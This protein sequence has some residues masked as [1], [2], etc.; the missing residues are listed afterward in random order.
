MAIV[1]TLSRALAVP[2]LLALGACSDEPAPTRTAPATAAPVSPAV[3]ASAPPAVTGDP[4]ARAAEVVA[5]LSDEDL[6]GQVLMPYAY[7]SSATQVDPVNR[8]GNQQLAGVDTPAEMITKYRLG[9]L[10]LVGFAPDDPTGKTNPTTNVENPEQVRALTAGL[11][12]AAG[13]I[14]AGAPLMIGMDQE[15]GIVTRVTEGVTMLPSALAFGAARQ[16]TLTEQAWRAAGTELAAMGVTVDFAPV[17]DTLGTAGGGVIGSRSFGSDA[18]ANSQQVA[19]AVR[20]LQ[21]SGVAAALKHFPGHGHTTAD[22]HDELPLIGQS[23]KAWEQQDLPPFKAGVDAGAGVVMS[24]HLNLQAIDKGVAATFSRKI[25]TDELR[26][27][28][29]FTGVA[30]TDAMNMAP[31]QKWPAGEAAVRALNAGNDMLLMPP[32]IGAARDGIVNAL[33]NGSL[34]RER[35]TEAVTRI[36]TLKFRTAQ[37]PQPELSVIG[38]P[39]HL[40]AVSALDAAA[41]TVLRGAC[42]GPLAR[43]PVSVSAPASR[44]VA[45]VNLVKALQGAGMQVQASGGSVIRLVGYGDQ[46]V[47][48]DD[49]AAITVMMDSPG[50][51]AQA[52]TRTLIATY[53]SSKLSLDAL[54]AVI[55]G[56]AKAPGRSP[57]AVGKLPRSAC[58]K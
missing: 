27:R 39:A 40:Q 22:S 44:E 55:A 52:N 46:R 35:L 45:R 41:V 15:Y 49:S 42:S 21:S 8:Q 36:L 3:T 1:R 34:K 38:S 7:G 57:V 43:G 13:K 2:L 19:A 58:A 30:V 4:A 9:G 6:A 5:R 10:I 51:L 32:D 31:A 25:M 26:G 20:G 48:L 12:D 17:A 23:R 53:S 16:P 54:A 47:D 37:T 50:L 56:K 11:Q 28:L 29:K 33:K 18:K 24:G 14:P